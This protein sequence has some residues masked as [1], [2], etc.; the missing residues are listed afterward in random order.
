MQ[1]VALGCVVAIALCCLALVY[2]AWSV[3]EPWEIGLDYS[4]FT[5]SISPEAWTSG[6]HYLGVGHTFIRF[7]STVTTVQF[8]HDALASSGPLRSRTADGLELTLELSFQYRLLPDSLYKMYTNYGPDFDLTFVKMGMD[9]LTVAA[10]K[11]EA[12]GFFVN[13][14]VIGIMM[15]E[16]LRS[17]FMACAFV[18]VPLF[19]FQAVSLPKDFESAI[20]ATQVAEQKI[21]RVQAEQS[22]LKVEYETEVIK[23]QRYLQ[24]REQQ[25]SAA[26][27]SIKLRNMADVNSFNATQLLAASAFQEILELF[28]GDTAKLLSYMKVRAIRDHPAGNTVLGIRD[29]VDLARPASLPVYAG[30]PAPASPPVNYPYP[31]GHR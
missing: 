4:L 31:A 1:K 19:Q 5:Q 8:S 29:D 23:A 21:K 25:A 7:N 28:K 2:S 11:H 30:H 3:L 14:T 12:R 18:A 24:V 17:H 22:M 27:E 26:Q 6:R 9:L 13:R 20:K 16:T 10:T 15:E